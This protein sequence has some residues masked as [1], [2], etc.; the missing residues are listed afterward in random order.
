[1]RRGAFDV[2]LLILCF[3]SL[4]ASAI[5]NDLFD[6]DPISEALGLIGLHVCK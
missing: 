6:D 5:F 1:M 2:A 4:Q 3:A